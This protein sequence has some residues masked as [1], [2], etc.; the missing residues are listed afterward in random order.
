MKN[1]EVKYATKEF[2]NS[3]TIKLVNKRLAYLVP[4]MFAKMKNGFGK[5]INGIVALYQEEI[6][7][8]EEIPAIK[9]PLPVVETKETEQPKQTPAVE[10]NKKYISKA[11]LKEIEELSK[12]QKRNS[13]A[14]KKLLISQ[15]FVQKLLTNRIKTIKEMNK[16]NDSV[17]HLSSIDVQEE[18]VL[19]YISLND[20]MKTLIKKVED[21]KS[22]MVSLAKTHGL[23][24]SMVE[25]AMMKSK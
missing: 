12:K 2:A 7:T 13:T 9:E 4:N 17:E 25:N 11:S 1:Y 18:A 21:I 20:E 10:N 3:T 6:T 22:Q 5:K 16:K 14:P 8:K 23:T 24:R 15:V 19:K